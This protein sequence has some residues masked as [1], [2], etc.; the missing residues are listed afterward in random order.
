MARGDESD[1]PQTD[2]TTRQELARDE[3]RKLIQDGTQQS[4]IAR[5]VGVSETGISQFL[6]GDEKAYGASFKS[7]TVKIERYLVARLE[8]RELFAGM[9][10]N[11]EYFPTPTGAKIQ[12]VLS[13]AHMAC[14]ISLI[15][16]G[17]GLSKTQTLKH[18]AKNRPNVFYVEFTRGT[19]RIIH[20]LEHICACLGTKADTR[21]ASDLEKTI[22]NKL[23]GRQGLLICDEAQHLETAALDSLRGIHDSAEVGVCFAGNESLYGRL[24]GARAADNSQI[25]SRIGKRLRLNKPVRGDVDALAAAWRIDQPE[26]VD[27]LF[28]ISQKPGAL[29]NATKVLRLA[30]VYAAG[31]PISAAHVRQGYGDLMGSDS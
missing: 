25:L 21:S 11:P 8:R 16:G 4:E 29:R 1:T 7:L 28:Q 20:A 31:S 26:A 6:K 27:L 13:Y 17:A 2:E 12:G 5:G 30:H 9:P 24:T 18:Y 15:L 23:R 14:D 22:G 3:L 19:G 10:T